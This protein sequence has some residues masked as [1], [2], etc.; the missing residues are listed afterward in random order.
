MEKL[1]VTRQAQL[2][3]VIDRLSGRGRIYQ[4]AE[5]MAAANEAARAPPLCQPEG[6]G[7]ER[8]AG[9]KRWRTAWPPGAGTVRVTEQRAGGGIVD[10]LAEAAARRGLAR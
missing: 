7:R 6:R 9:R 1:G 8:E 4:T 3:E 5:A 10:D 2:V